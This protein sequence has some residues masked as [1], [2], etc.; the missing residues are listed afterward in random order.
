MQS[1]VRMKIIDYSH[2]VCSIFIHCCCRGSVVAVQGVQK[3]FGG[4]V[5]LHPL[6]VL[7]QDA[8][9]QGLHDWLLLTHENHSNI[10]FRVGSS[11][12]SCE[13]LWS[14]FN[15]YQLQTPACWCDFV[16]DRHHL[17]Q[18]HW[19][20]EFYLL[21][22]TSHSSVQTRHYLK[23]IVFILVITQVPQFCKYCCHSM[24]LSAPFPHALS[25]TTNQPKPMQLKPNEKVKWKWVI[26]MLPLFHNLCH[27]DCERGCFSF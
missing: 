3:S 8:E 4:I 26:A 23:P 6:M 13:C 2:L 20:N 11:L 14:I 22:A 9:I 15:V 18:T 25:M 19:N 17:G 16:Q 12:T 5:L 21:A 10:S 1:I 27:F 7:L 24:M